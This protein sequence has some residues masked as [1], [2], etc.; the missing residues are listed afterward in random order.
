VLFGHVVSHQHFLSLF[1][2]I[3]QSIVFGVARQVTPIYS[4][5]VQQQLF[6]KK[7][8]EDA[9]S[10]KALDKEVESNLETDLDDRLRKLEYHGTALITQ[11]TSPAVIDE[12]RQVDVCLALAGGSL[13]AASSC[14]GVL[15][16]FQQK[17]VSSPSTGE[18]VSAMDLVK[19]N[20][21]ISGGSIPSILYSYAKVTTEELLELD[22]TTDPSKITAESLSMIPE[23]SM[24]YVIARKP[25]VKRILFR[26]ILKVLSKPTNIFKMHSLWSG[27]VYKKVCEPL[28]MPKNKFFTSSKEELEKILKDN[29]QFKESDFLLP[30]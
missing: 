9:A 28:K 19:Y 1:L 14:Y 11:T 13:R 16:G 21:G 7:N 5:Q 4:R 10:A 6:F 30:R 22:S 12:S 29:P 23:T 15:R 26:S 25:D 20:S 2:A 24:G 8:Y 3:K 17:R 27:G 18:D